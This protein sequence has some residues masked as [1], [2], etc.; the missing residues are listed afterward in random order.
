[1]GDMDEVLEIIEELADDR[2]VPRNIRAHIQQ[3]MDSLKDEKQST[4]VKLSTAISFLDEASNDPN[5][6]SHAR[7]QIWNIV[8]MLESLQSEAD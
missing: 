3:A 7:T 1:M 8:G 4:T 2:R 5:I 6:P